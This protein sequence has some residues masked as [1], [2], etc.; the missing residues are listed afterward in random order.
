MSSVD[1]QTNEVTQDMLD[2]L[3]GPAAPNDDTDDG[4][5]ILPID[6]SRPQLAGA[7]LYGLAG[8]IVRK[9]APETESHPAG[10][11]IQTLMYFGN[12]IGRTAY[13]QAGETRHYGNLFAVTVGDTSKA[14]KGTGKVFRTYFINNRGDEA[15]GTTWS[16]LDITPLGRQETWEDSPEGY[17]QNPPYKWWNWHDN[18]SAE[19]T[20]NPNWIDII[21]DPEGA[22]RRRAEEEKG[23]C[24]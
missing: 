16:Y 9:I 7:A 6:P 2:F 17:P 23:C 19:P 20:P 15:M 8:D 22:V 21:T 10:L 1:P 14:R 24:S 13:Y 11:L 18:Y 4:R 5:K 12:V 3:R